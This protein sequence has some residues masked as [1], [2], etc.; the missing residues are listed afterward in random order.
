MGNSRMIQG[1][2]V[3][4]LINFLIFV[5]QLGFFIKMILLLLWW[6]MFLVLQSKRVRVVLMSMSIMKLMQVLLLIVVVFIVLIFWLSGISDL[7]MVLRLKMIQNQDMYCFFLF[8]DG[9]FIMMVFWVVYSRLVQMLRN[10][11]VK[12]MNLWFWL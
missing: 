4:V 3:I 10:V 2:R 7:M 8:L 12:M 1:V 11:F 5:F 9:Q 6:M